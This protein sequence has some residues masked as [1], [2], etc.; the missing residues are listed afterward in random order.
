MGVRSFPCKLLKNVMMTKFHILK[1]KYIENLALQRISK[2]KKL[3]SYYRYDAELHSSKPL[4]GKKNI[5]SV[6][7]FYKDI[8]SFRVNFYINC[9]YGDYI[10]L[11]DLNFN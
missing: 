1:K 9:K 3:T 2:K 8:E 5:A 10:I 7:F 4:N 6:N 11:D